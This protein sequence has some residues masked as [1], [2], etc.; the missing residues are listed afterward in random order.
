MITRVCYICKKVL[1]YIPDEQSAVSHGL[2]RR[3]ALESYEAAGILEP[4]E[5][6]E[7]AAIRLRLQRERD[8]LNRCPRCFE[9]V[10]K[11]IELCKLGGKWLPGKTFNHWFPLGR[12]SVCGQE[13]VC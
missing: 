10:L 6:E 8:R 5:K 11:D 7:L 3:C 4:K 1:G 12:P 9:K 2:C 13:A